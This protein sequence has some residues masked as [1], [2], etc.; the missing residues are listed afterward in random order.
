MLCPHLIKTAQVEQDKAMAATWFEK[1]A[2]EG[3]PQAMKN[4]GNMS[5]AE[6][7]VLPA[8]LHLLFATDLAMP[9]SQV[10]RG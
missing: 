5:V 4:L 1:A 2:R 9:I 3:H 10:P 6:F 8:C 7:S